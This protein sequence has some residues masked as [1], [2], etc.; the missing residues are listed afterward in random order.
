MAEKLNTKVVSFSLAIFSGIVYILCALF[1]AI[2]PQTTLN[3][4]KD[5]FHGIDITKIT[6]AP[7]PLGSTIIGFIEIVVLLLI[8]GWLFATIYNYLLNKINGGKK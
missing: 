1:F 2:V 3:L 6:N 5:M 8:V 4:F 7:V